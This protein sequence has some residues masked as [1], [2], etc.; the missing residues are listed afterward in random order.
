MA[1]ENP[2]HPQANDIPAVETGSALPDSAVPTHVLDADNYM[3]EDLDGITESLFGSG[4]LNY[5]LLQGRQ[6]DAAG[7]AGGFDGIAPSEMES[8]TA[9]AALMNAGRAL[10]DAAGLE[11]ALAAKNGTDAQQGNGFGAAHFP[12][13]GGDGYEGDAFDNLRALAN[14]STLSID[15]LPAEP[16]PRD[17]PPADNP[18]DDTPPDGTPPDDNP[19]DDHPPVDNPPTDPPPTDNP[20]TDDPPA[21]EDDIDVL[22]TNDL[23]LPVVDINLDPLEEIVGDIDIGV[24]ISHGDDGVT[25]G[26]DT[27]LLDIPVLDATVNLDVP[28]VTPVVDAVLDVTDPVLGGVTDTVQP[29]VDGI[30]DTV[31]SIIDSLLGQPPADDGDVDLSVHQDLG[32]PQIDVNL[33][34]VEEIVGD[35]DIVA[36]IVRTDDGVSIDV[37]TIVADIPVA[38]LDLD[39]DIPVVM[40]V[41]N[42]AVDPVAAFLDNVT[43]ADTLE[44]LVDNPVGTL[45]EIAEDA[46]ETVTE[47]VEGA[48]A[49]L[50]DAVEDVL[51]QIG[52][53]DNSPD[54][55]DIAVSTPLGLPPIEISLDLVEAITGDIDLA[56]G[57]TEN[58]GALG[59]NL[60]SVV[61]GIDLTEGQ[62]LGVEVP[63]IA[64][65]LESLLD[66]AATPQEAIENALDSAAGSLEDTVGDVAEVIGNLADVLQ[67]GTD[68]ITGGLTEGI[69]ALGDTVE[70]GIIGGGLVH[71]MLDDL[72][73]LGMA[74]GDPADTDIDIGNN[75]GLPQIDIVLDTVENIVGDIDVGL[76]LGLDNN[77][78]T[79]DIDLTALG[80]DLTNGTQEVDIPLAMPVVEDVLDIAEDILGTAA[81]NDTEA[82]GAM[83]LIDSVLESAEDLLSIALGGTSDNGSDATWPILNTDGAGGIAGIAEGLGLPGGDGG[84]GLNLLEPVGDLTEGFGLLSGGGNDHNQGGGLLSGLGNGLLGGGLFG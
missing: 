18:P 23:N 74:D 36:D 24:D 81:G 19:P 71:D 47:A 46:V 17:E 68:N 63:V 9:L 51:S 50:Q 45:G 82:A 64:P 76:D 5:L 80:I 69:G 42:G 53:Q 22:G 49:G 28:L 14:D 59:L 20:P 55:V 48:V 58:D 35:I 56:L 40:P 6:S 31:E 37:G 67:G 29:I 41:V 52:Q 75:I 61:A 72:S 26:I 1:T 2:T 78:V 12:A 10:G 38:D 30:G 25:I 79:L 73:G 77:G 57:L 43:S 3:A 7:V 21:G 32:L 39:L 34:V 84:G 60:D 15:P 4:N 70:N 54:D 13:H 27:V 66:P 33:D 16:P 44:N 62:V 65:V 83:G 11:N 8:L